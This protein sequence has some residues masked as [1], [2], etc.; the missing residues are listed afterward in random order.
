[1]NP[2]HD[3]APD[4]IDQWADDAAYLVHLDDLAL[5]HFLDRTDDD[6]TDDDA[7]DPEDRRWWYEQS[8]GPDQYDGPTPIEVLACAA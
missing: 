7:I 1:M 4:L 3:D 6:G 5:E 8:P 2:I